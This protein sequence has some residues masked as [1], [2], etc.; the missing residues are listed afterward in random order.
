MIKPVCQYSSQRYSNIS[1]TYILL[2]NIDFAIFLNLSIVHIFLSN[3]CWIYIYIKKSSQKQKL[4]NTNKNGGWESYKDLTE[5]NPELTKLLEDDDI[6]T[7]T[8]FNENL[9]KIMN[10]VKFRAFGK[11]SF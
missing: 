9:Q 2:Y 11:V 10:K 8:P 5:D 4:W 7:P 3:K 1:P 6:S